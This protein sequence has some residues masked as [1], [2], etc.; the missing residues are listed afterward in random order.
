MTV[1]PT[2]DL[3]VSQVVRQLFGTHLAMSTISERSNEASILTFFNIEAKQ[4]WLIPKI[5]K[6]EA[7]RTLL[8]REL[9]KIEEK[10][11]CLFK[12]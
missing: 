5:L 9:T 8:I 4:T 2:S 6:I 12:M 11:L 7:K 3:V 10:R 1:L